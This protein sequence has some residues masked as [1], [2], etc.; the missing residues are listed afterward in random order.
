MFDIITKFDYTLSSKNRIEYSTVNK[1][2]V[3]E[4]IAELKKEKYTATSHKTKKGENY[5]DY[6][7]S[8]KNTTG[9][10]ETLFISIMYPAASKPNEPITIIVFK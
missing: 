3:N 9:K 2:F 8:I 6:K 1:D 5:T 7:K 4:I 10:L